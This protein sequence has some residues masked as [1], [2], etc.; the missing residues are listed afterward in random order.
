M[1]WTVA[2]RSCRKH[3]C[4]STV[5]YS[6]R[7][8]YLILNTQPFYD[9]HHWTLIRSNER[10][11]SIVRST[12][13]SYIHRQA[14]RKRLAGGRTRRAYPQRSRQIMG[15]IVEDGPEKKLTNILK[16]LEPCNYVWRPTRRWPVDPQQQHERP[17]PPE[18]PVPSQWRSAQQRRQ[19]NSSWPLRAR[20]RRT[21]RL[22][23]TL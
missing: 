21:R 13:S 8:G 22:R 11:S 23:P 16:F 1:R 6:R 7:A 19:P 2:L 5:P 4:S 3:A 10:H 17:L 12:M 14:L 9:S 20:C 15:V 18:F